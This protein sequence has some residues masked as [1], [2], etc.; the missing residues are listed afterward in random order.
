[1]QEELEHYFLQSTEQAKQLEMLKQEHEQ[2]QQARD[3]AL[4]QAEVLQS[5]LSQRTAERDAAAHQLEMLK[6]EHEQ[7]LAQAQQDT[8]EAREEAE[9]TL[10]QLHQVQ[11]E[12]EHYFL[13]SRGQAQQLERYEALLRRSEGLLSAAAR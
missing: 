10:L 12:L 4:R 1:M 6:Q 8:T 2:A 7:A 5:E 11:E 9:L 13:L 3:E